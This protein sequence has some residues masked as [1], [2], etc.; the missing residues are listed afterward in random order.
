MR[1][2]LIRRFFYPSNSSYPVRWDPTYGRIDRDIQWSVQDLLPR[3]I[4]ERVVLEERLQEK[5]KQ[6]AKNE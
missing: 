6:Q 2:W 4:G 3:S 1:K 5:R